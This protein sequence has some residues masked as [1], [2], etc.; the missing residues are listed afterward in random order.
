MLKFLEVQHTETNSEVQLVALLFTRNAGGFQIHISHLYS[1]P[2]CPRQNLQLLTIEVYKPKSNF[3]L[4]FMK[5]IF[6][7]KILRINLGTSVHCC[8]CAINTCTAKRTIVRIAVGLV[9]HRKFSNRHTGAGGGGL[10]RLQ[11]STFL[12]MYVVKIK[13]Y[14]PNRK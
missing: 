10:G 2:Y 13:A 4:S 14:D 12:L 3:N 11:T 8:S 5:E 9:Q 1:T 6:I 7:E